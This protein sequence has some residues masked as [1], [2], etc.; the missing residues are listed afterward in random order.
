LSQGDKSKLTRRQYL[1]VAGGVAA[2]AAVAGLG[3]YYYGPAAKPKQTD[4]RVLTQTG[5][6]GLPMTWWMDQWNTKNAG[7]YHVSYETVPYEMG[8][9]AKML[10]GAQLN[11]PMYSFLPFEDA[12][13][14]AF[15]PVLE[16]IM[17]WV[18][19]DNLDISIFPKNMLQVNTYKG[20]TAG[21]PFRALVYCFYYRKDVYEDKGLVPPKT[22]EDYYNNA[23]K[24]NDP[25]N[26]YGGGLYLSDPNQFRMWFFSQG[27]TLLTPDMTDVTDVNGP[28]GQ[29][30]ISMLDTWKKLYDEK[31]VPPGAITMAGPDQHPMVKQGRIAACTAASAQAVTYFAAD[32]PVRDKMVAQ[33]LFMQGPPG[34]TNTMSGLPRHDAGNILPCCINKNSTQA[35][36]EAAWDLCKFVTSYDMQLASVDH[37]NCP[38]RTD[39][40]S[41]DKYK[42]YDHSWETELYGYQDLLLW[43]TPAMPDFFSIITFEVGNFMVGKQTSKEA[44][45][46]IWKRF[47]A[48]LVSAAAK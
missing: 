23:K 18:K 19:K 41:T 44:T 43:I 40:L 24:A 35:E 42:Q 27:G 34:N 38:A 36:K 17:D 6:A 4:I 30:C 31:L 28:D 20:K 47:K 9:Y 29:L 3:Y 7:K 26:M 21:L 5:G 48:A 39:V 22:Y 15:Y 14:P 33:P 13:V 1:K 32:S 37:A 10:V 12:W 16:D 11:P 45:Q 8:E 46:N 25:P 2:A